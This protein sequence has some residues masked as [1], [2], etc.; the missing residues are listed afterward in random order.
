M[1]FRCFQNHWR[2]LYEVYTR[3]HR[4]WRRWKELLAGP[5][6]LPTTIVPYELRELYTIGEKS[7][8]LWNSIMWCNVTF[9]RTNFLYWVHSFSFILLARQPNGDDEV[10]IRCL[11]SCVSRTMSIASLTFSCKQFKP[12]TVQ[13]YVEFGVCFT[14]YHDLSLLFVNS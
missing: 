7:E 12:A 2:I 14:N 11:H 4:N 10:E 5:N 1:R 8:T 9:F 6:G 3:R 13:P